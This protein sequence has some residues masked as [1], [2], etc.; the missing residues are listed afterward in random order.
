MWALLE[1]RAEEVSIEEAGLDAFEDDWSH[2]L[3]GPVANL[4][5]LELLV[6][7]ISIGNS[8]QKEDDSRIGN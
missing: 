1:E 5:V 2:F 4:M 6:V 3:D 8:F 7:A